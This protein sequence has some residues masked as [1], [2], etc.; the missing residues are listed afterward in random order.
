MDIVQIPAQLI[1]LRRKRVL[2]VCHV[3]EGLCC[4]IYEAILLSNCEDISVETK[5]LEGLIAHSP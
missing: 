5:F 4:S 3:E 1:E 2:V